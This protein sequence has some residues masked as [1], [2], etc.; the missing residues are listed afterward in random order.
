MNNEIYIFISLLHQLVRMFAERRTFGGPRK[1]LMLLLP[2]MYKMGVMTTMIGGLLVLT[3]KGLTI[4][5]ILLILAVS[6]LFSK[7]KQYGHPH[8]GPTDIHVHIHNDPHGQAYSSWHQEHVDQPTYHVE[9]SGHYHRR[10]SP[11]PPPQQL[12]PLPYSDLL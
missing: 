6:N 7:H 9:H 1:R 11:P 4:G 8:Y 2:I 3:L 5:V 10:W 12:A